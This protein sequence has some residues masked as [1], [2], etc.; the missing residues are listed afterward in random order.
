MLK[1]L[2]ARVQLFIRKAVL[3]R[4]MPADR[5]LAPG[6]IRYLYAF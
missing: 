6:M 1:S 4:A 2:F 3:L 5:R